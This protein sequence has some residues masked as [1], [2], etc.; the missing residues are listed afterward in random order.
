MGSQGL[1][2]PLSG[3]GSQ[4][5]SEDCGLEPVPWT[6]PINMKL[7]RQSSAVEHM[8]GPGCEHQTTWGGG[9][10]AVAKRYPRSG[11]KSPCT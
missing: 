11:H 5:T 3:Q 8:R 2:S 9:G 10:S 1:P 7:S 6:K 4:L